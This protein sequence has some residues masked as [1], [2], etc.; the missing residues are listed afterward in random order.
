MLF[1]L[2]AEILGLF[3]NSL[4]PDDKDSLPHRNNFPQQIEI[5]LYQKPKT[6]SGFFVS[7][8]KC[9]SNFQYF[10]ENLS[11]IA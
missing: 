8:L 1:L 9:P 6:F 3:V 7:L 11:L 5:Q 4:T 2:R 10:E